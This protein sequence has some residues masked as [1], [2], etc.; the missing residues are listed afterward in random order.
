MKK[1]YLLTALLCLGGIG[2]HAERITRTT[3]YGMKASNKG[4][5]PCSG[6]TRQVC[7][8]V[9]VE[10]IAIDP[11]STLLTSETKDEKGNLIKAEVKMVPKPE[12]EIIEELLIP[13]DVNQETEIVK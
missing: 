13:N 5:N 6:A 8:V 3:Y 12:A 2:I 7:A 10:A 11:N 1:I 9:E 4:N